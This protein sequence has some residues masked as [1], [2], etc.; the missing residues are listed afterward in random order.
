MKPHGR[1]ARMNSRSAAL[2]SSPETPVMN[3]RLLM[4]PIMP[5][6][7]PGSRKPPLI[8]LDDALSA[9]GFKIAADLGGLFSRAEWTDH[10]A[11][12][13]AL[14]DQIRAFDHRRPRP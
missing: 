12:I 10:G 6:T 13:N 9:G 14:V 5:L 4:G 2:N 8:P 11:V 1:S 3:A 7:A